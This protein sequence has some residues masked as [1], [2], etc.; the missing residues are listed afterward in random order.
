MFT[1]QFRMSLHSTFGIQ[2]YS[3]IIKKQWKTESGPGGNLSS[4]YRIDKNKTRKGYQK[5]KKEKII[6]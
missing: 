1:G 2:M 4:F 5:K 3:A 6:A